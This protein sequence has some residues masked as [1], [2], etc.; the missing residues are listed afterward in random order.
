MS[1]TGHLGAADNFYIGGATAGT[2]HTYIGDAN[3]NVTIFNGATFTVAS[4]ITNLN[5]GLDVNGNADISGDLVVAGKISQSGVIDREEWG[6][7]YVVAGSGS[8]Q[9][10]LTSGG[11]ALPNGG[12]YR[13]TGHIS[14][15]GTDNV[16]VAV[17]WNENGTWYVNN[18]YFGGSTSNHVNFL[19]SGAVPK[20]SMMSHSGTY[21][22]HVTH[23]HLSL[24]EG[25]G[26]D[27]LRGYFGADSYLSWQENGDTLTIAGTLDVN[28]PADISGN[29]SGVNTLTCTDLTIGSDATTAIGKA[30]LKTPNVSAVSY[31]RINANETLSLLN[32]AQ[33]LSAIGGA[34]IGGSTGRFITG[35]LYG[36]GHSNSILP[37]W[38]YNAGNP[39]YGIGYTESSPDNLRIDVSNNLMSGT[40]DFQVLPNEAKVN[41]N[42][43]YHTG[44]IPT[45]NQN[46]TGSSASCTGNAA[47]A[48]NST[49]LN[50][51]TLARIDHAEDFRTYTGLN[52]SAAQ[53]K[54]Y[55]VGRLYGCPAHWDGNWQNIE[56]N[57][58]AES[59]ESAN[60]RFAI[61][62]DYTGANNQASMLKLYLKEASGPY[63]NHFRFVMG[64]PVDAGWNHS[65]QDTYYVDLYAEVKSYGQFKM[66]VKSYGH[67]IQSANPTSGG[68]TTVFY[69]SPTVSNIS[70]FTEEHNTIHHL[71]SEIYHEGHKPT[72]SELGAQAAGTYSTATGVANNAD[73][74]PSWVPSSDPSYL[75]ASSTQSKYLRSD[76]HDT[77]NSTVTSTNGLGFKV[78]SSSSARIEI[79]SGGTSWAYLRL[80]DDSTVSWDLGSE[81]GGDF[82]I[83]PGGSGTNGY[84]FNSS[85]VFT[86]GDGFTSTKG[87]TAYGWGDHGLSAQDKTDI[88]NLSGTNTGDQTTVSGSSGS[89]TGNAATVTI[90]STFNGTYPLLVEV[91]AS[92]VIYNNPNIT[93][94][95]TSNTLTSPNFSGNL[96]GNVTGNTSGSSGS[97]TGNAATA[98]KATKIEAGGGGPSQENLNTIADSVST[99]QLEYRGFN[100]STSNGPATSDNANGVITV[101]QH[102]SNYSAQLAFSSN[103][104]MYWRD[105]PNGVHG[106]WRKMW[107]DGNDGATSGL[108]AQ[109]AAACTGNA[110]TA[111]NVAYT[112]LTGTVPT[113]NQNTTGTATNANNVKTTSVSNS[114]TYFGVFVDA[115]GTAYQDL[116][117]GAGLQYNPEANTLTTGKLTTD[118][119]SI[120][121]NA[122]SNA[123]L[124]TLTGAGAGNEANITLKLAGTVH[125]SPVKMKMIAENGD[126]TGVG[127]GII[128]YH[129]NEDTLG[130]GQTT[131]HNSMAIL[132]DNSDVV[133]M[134]NQTTFTNG[135]YVSSAV[136]STSQTTGTVKIAGG[137]GIVKTLNVGGDVVAYASS[138][139]RYKDNLKP[140]TNP[141]DKVKSLTGYT[142]TWN[143]NH[144]QFNGN[145]DIGV[146]A[147]EVEKV[148]PE[149][150]DTRDNGY[151][152]VKYEKM[153]A[154]LIEAVKEQQKQIDELKTMCN[155]CSK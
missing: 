129:P 147:Q 98:T 151:K 106:G 17:F 66:N 14:G 47:T 81:N 127:N 140:I 54:R 130:I 125:G 83:R 25:T 152:A 108:S 135:I 42:T 85:G 96:T 141:I 142:F 115:N 92:G 110:A 51:F 36:T 107:D 105:N 117:V 45:W 62:G 1:G 91:T 143:D 56:I 72:L 31:Q 136:Q 128:S 33:M 35:G 94:N 71:T 53:A 50:G 150:V 7:T 109:T 44:N 122:K 88:G 8:P 24:E 77:T 99:G 38:Q 114:A 116:H 20:V 48:T 74:T 144:E 41:G 78:D 28:G 4:G 27:N 121:E 55:H 138:D 75:T 100:N 79:E 89:C 119:A 67:G 146:V 11:G 46:T 84:H 69:D 37:I 68:A 80:R 5:G 23:E 102:S 153:V 43:V 131:T 3:R 39:G 101:G 104:N 132:I 139:E 29:L 19:I 113:W 126:G 63:C 2:D 97:C 40:P 26:T 15:T 13:V 73:V 95:G 148:L 103:G 90:N 118:T 58:T 87:N 34:P 137:V 52:A 16:A 123:A 12:G 64:T 57:V 60:L 49:Q 18:T 6:R 134:K 32:A 61:M 133:S 111:T 76:A 22:I 70:A 86:S 93:Y 145:D 155:G 9:T 112:G 82:E 65:N 59:Y 154:L 124:M 149:I 10:L 21:S 30:Y 120:V